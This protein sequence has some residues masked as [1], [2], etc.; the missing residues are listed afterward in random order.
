MFDEFEIFF[1]RHGEVAVQAILENLER[2]EG[3]QGNASVPLER[4]WH[5]LMQQK[6]HHEVMGCAA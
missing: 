4:R 3:L 1:A 2:Y 6:P 5:L